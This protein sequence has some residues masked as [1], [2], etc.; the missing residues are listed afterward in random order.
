MKGTPPFEYLEH[1]AD[2]YVAAYGSSLEE[3]FANAA[4]ALFEVMTEVEKIRPIL[5]QDFTVEGIDKEGL[6]YSWLEALLV[7][8]E[9][10]ENLFSS[11][12]IHEIKATPEGLSLR[13]TAYGEPFDPKRHPQKVAVKGITYHR[14]E[15]LED[16]KGFVTAK[17]ILDI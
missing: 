17:F 12:I 9:T 6:L 3:C 2:I 15:I 8:F 1:T 14:M 13:A 4:L 10:T 5:S 11:F 16:D 7:S